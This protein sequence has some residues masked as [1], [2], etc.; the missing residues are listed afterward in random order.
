MSL[1]VALSNG[2]TKEPSQVCWTEAGWLQA[3]W[4]YDDPTKRV[5]RFYPPHRI[6]FVRKTE[7]EDEEP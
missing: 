4:H 6:K 5:R 7:I 1:L 2:K 3:T